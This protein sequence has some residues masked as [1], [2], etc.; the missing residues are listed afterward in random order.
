ML[1]RISLFV[2]ILAALAAGTLSYFEV[3]DKIPALQKQRDDEHTG[4]QQALT[5][6]SSTKTKLAKTQSDLT[7]SQADLAETKSDRDK[8][9]ARAEAQVKRADELSVKLARAI[10]ER[11]DAQNELASFTVI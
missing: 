11:D 8:A 10:Q 4:K 2:A 1:L 9:V 3:T 6:L 5:E 7:Q